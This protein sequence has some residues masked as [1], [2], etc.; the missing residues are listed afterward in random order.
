MGDRPRP[1]RPTSLAGAKTRSASTE[2][3][4]RRVTRA[5]DPGRAGLRG[6][7]GLP[8]GEKNGSVIY[9]PAVPAR[10]AQSRLDQRAE[11]LQVTAGDEAAIEHWGARRRGVE[12]HGD[13]AS[14]GRP[15]GPRMA[16]AVA[17]GLDARGRV[18]QSFS[19][20]AASPA[21][22]WSCSARSSRR[23]QR[24]ACRHGGPVDYRPVRLP[25]EARDPPQ[26][27]PAGVGRP[28]HPPSEAFG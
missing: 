1:R 2:G 6:Q 3:D 26:S 11:Q 9:G 23:N 19:I 4:T 18:S 8:W 12:A 5:T 20:T 17:M 15:T 14:R 10:P 7:L 25:R 21:V 22:T 27:R 16:R 24:R 13:G 28:G